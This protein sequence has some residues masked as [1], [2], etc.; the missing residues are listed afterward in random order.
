[1]IY[2]GKVE[3]FD[4]E[5]QQGT[6]QPNAGGQPLSFRRVDVQQQAEEPRC[7]TYFGYETW[8]KDDGETVAVH[9]RQLS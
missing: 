8:T 5:T 6:I 4:S 7:E 2:Y 3:T 1:M 9:L